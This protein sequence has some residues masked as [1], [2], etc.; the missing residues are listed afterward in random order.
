MTADLLELG[1]WLA[2]HGV[3]HMAM[4]STGVCWKAPWNLLDPAD[5]PRGPRTRP[6]GSRS[7]T[8]REGSRSSRPARRHS[9]GLSHT[10]G[11]RVREACLASCRL[12]ATTRR[13]ERV[14]TK[15]SRPPH[16]R[17]D[18]AAIITINKEVTTG[19][20]TS[21]S[22]SLRG[23]LHHGWPKPVDWSGHLVVERTG[24]FSGIDNELPD[25]GSTD[26]CTEERSNRKGMARR[27]L[28]QGQHRRAGPYILALLHVG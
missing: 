5:T 19:E 1:D 26:G 2:G 6:R 13:G 18:E 17:L 15:L 14:Q 10:V 25:R 8:R 20:E 3:T 21:T 9:R 12:P 16:R 11:Q 28:E 24:Q 4:E 27:G 23:T 22:R 7:R